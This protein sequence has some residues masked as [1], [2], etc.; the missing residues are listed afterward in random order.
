MTDA[1][2]IEGFK[3]FRRNL[4][5]LDRDLGKAVRLAFNDA[6][7]LVV[8]DA[9]ARVPARSGRARGTVRALSTQTFARVSGGGNRAPY[10]PW[11]D[12]GGRVGRRHAVR[13]PFLKEGRYIYRSFSQNRGRFIEVMQDGLVKVARDAGFE[14]E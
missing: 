13:R 11:L 10:Y 5:A 14:V 9:R 6:A 2:K 4:R 3:E 12:F 1:V 7:D 8:Q